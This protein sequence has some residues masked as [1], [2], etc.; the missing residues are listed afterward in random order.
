MDTSAPRRPVTARSLLCAVLLLASVGTLWMALTTEIIVT[1]FQEVGDLIRTLYPEGDYIAD[2]PG[3]TAK[4]YE[5]FIQIMENGSTMLLNLSGRAQQIYQDL[6]Q[7]TG[8]TVGAGAKQLW[9]AGDIAPALLIFTFSIL[10]PVLKTLLMGFVFLEPY[11]VKGKPKGAAILKL[12]NLSH[13]YTMLDVFVVSISVFAFS[14]NALVTV[15]PAE[16]VGWY[17]GYMVI[18]YMGLTLLQNNATVDG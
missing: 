17:I 5:G 14:K 18:S 9:D 10:M 8:Y 1:R 4:D 2:N 12:L 3:N 13:K 7:P 16:A 11:M 15:E 6:T